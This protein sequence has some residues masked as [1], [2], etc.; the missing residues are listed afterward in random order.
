MQ[1]ILKIGLIIASFAMASVSNAEVIKATAILDYAQEVG[2]SNPNPSDSMGMAMLSF[3]TDT[4]MLSLEATIDGIFLQDITFPSGGLMFGNAGPFHIH[5]APAGSNG[6]VV[7][8]ISL[9]SYFAETM[10][11]ISVSVS[12]LAFDDSLIAELNMGNLYL[13]LHTLDY[14]SGEVR[15][16]LA[17]VS[18]PGIALMT[19]FGIFLLFKRK[20]LLF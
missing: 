19:C 12:G 3:D 14:G 13:N 15:G 9:E 17:R 1:K 10:S 4:M 5:N 8:P 20:R 18:A 2:P 16:Q 7:L 6:G 11:G